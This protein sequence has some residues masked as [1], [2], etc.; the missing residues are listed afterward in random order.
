[1]CGLVAFAKASRRLEWLIKP[2]AIAETP[3]RASTV[4]CFE[5]ENT[6][7]SPTSG[8]VGLYIQV[9]FAH[10]CPSAGVQIAYRAMNHI[11]SKAVKIKHKRIV[12]LRGAIKVET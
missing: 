6:L 12:E 8:P 3:P 9:H 7:Q 2:A 11:I 5:R 1:M 4:Q 10:T